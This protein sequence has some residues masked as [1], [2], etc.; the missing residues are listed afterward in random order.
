LRR[1]ILDPR[2]GARTEL[3]LLL[4]KKLTIGTPDHANWDRMSD[5][6]HKQADL[7]SAAI[8]EVTK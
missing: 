4:L 2:R 1:R 5:W 3:A 8:K 6:L 7:Y